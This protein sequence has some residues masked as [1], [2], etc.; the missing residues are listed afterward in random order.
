M[1]IENNKED[2]NISNS[3]ITLTDKEFESNFGLRISKIVD[4]FRD[5]FKFISGISKKSATI[6]G[7]TRFSSDD[8]EYIKALKLGELLSSSGYTVVTGGGPGIM[9]AANKGAYKSEGDSVGINI[10]LPENQ[11]S[12]QFVNKSIGFHYFFTRKM[13]MSFCSS[14]YV[15]FPGGYGTLDEFFEMVVLLQTK[16]LSHKVTIVVI[17]K[18]FW[19]PLLS[20]FKEE[21]YNNRGSINEEELSLFKLVDT[22]EEA[23]VYILEKDINK[24]N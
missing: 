12:N 2:I 5:G 19:S 22:P 9:E 18:D 11:E 14:V 4:E 20:W 1:K 10:E 17:G 16:K 24:N 13:M 23:L 7:G 6:F 21:L 3:N 8:A 15:F